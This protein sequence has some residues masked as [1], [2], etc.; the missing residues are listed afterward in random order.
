MDKKEKAAVG[1]PY[2]LGDVAK[3]TLSK[4]ERKNTNPYDLSET[5]GSRGVGKFKLK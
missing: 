1:N 2:D 4:K 5:S 3:I